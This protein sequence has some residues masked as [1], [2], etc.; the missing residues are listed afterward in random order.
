MADEPTIDPNAVPAG[1]PAEPEPEPVVDPT[2][3]PEPQP[4]PYEIPENL[5]SR[6]KSAAELAEFA[7]QK[8]SEAD[9]LQAKV[10]AYEQQ[11]PPVKP[12]ETQPSS[13]EMLEKL[14]KDPVGFVKELTDDIRAQVA[15][16][17]FARTHP[18][19][20]E[21]RGDIA[22]IV[23]RTPGI[24]ADPEGLDMVYNYVARQ[25][26]ADK[27]NSASAIKN[28]HANEVQNLK[29][30]GAVVEGS[31]APKKGSSPLIKPGMS[32]DEMDKALDDAGVGWISDEERHKVE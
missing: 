32:P 16:S 6:Y 19:L 8:Q 3:E 15:L 12:T 29:K 10:D 22:A 18:K 7:A 27:L 23:N 20:D 4:D 26:E 25:K 21:Y 28:A 9:R 11:H 2:A 1:E 24:L 31:T 14:A 13:D 5:K 30:T 17:E